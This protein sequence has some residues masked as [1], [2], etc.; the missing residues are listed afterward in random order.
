MKIKLDPFVVSI[1]VVIVLA[2]FFPELGREGNVI[3]LDTIVSVGISLIFFSYGLKLSKHQLTSGLKNW[4]L[5]ALV[6]SSTFLLFPAIVISFYPFIEQGAE[7]TIWLAFLFLAALPST[8]SSSVVMVSMAKGNIPAA[9]FNA[10]I[11]GL[12]GIVLTP[13]WIGLFLQE[14]GVD[15]NLG[16]IYLK[17]L[18]EILLPVVLGL[19]L[20][21]Y[22]GKFVQKYARQL[23]LFD[24]SIILLIIYKSFVE[25]FDEGVFTSVKI[26]DLIFIS[27]ATLLLFYVVYFITGYLSRVLKFNKEDQ[28]TAQFCGTKKSLVHGT[29]F[30]KVLFPESMSVGLVILPLM[31]F[32]AFQI[33]FISFVASRLSNRFRE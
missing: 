32:H 7:E 31:I 24:K 3:P 9:I 33:L 12:I 15:Y 10:S 27:I 26:R 25:S 8:V 20:Q 1:I 16:G 4:R 13:L 29:V 21:Q 23:S 14:S 19:I 18:L 11:S 22:L 6:Q 30:S 28:I 2:Y 17:L 5:H